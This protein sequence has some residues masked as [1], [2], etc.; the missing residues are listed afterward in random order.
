VFWKQ[1]R[2][3]TPPGNTDEA[4]AARFLAADTAL[5]AAVPSIRTSLGPDT[6]VNGRLSFT[7]PTRIEGTLRGEVR[8]SDML[9]VG[10]TATVQGVVRALKLIVLGEVRGEARAAEWVEIGRSGRLTGKI[11][12]QSL[13][14]REGGYLNG[15]CRIVPTRATVHVLRPATERITDSR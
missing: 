3:P 2:N 6:V 13:V 8:A 15:D 7:E 9:V 4:D 1:R 10:E 5:V 11:E 12:A 14:V